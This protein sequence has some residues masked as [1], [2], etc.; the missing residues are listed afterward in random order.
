MIG[1]LAVQ[2]FVV[3]LF[4]IEPKKRSLEEIASDVSVSPSPAKP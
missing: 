4:G 2:I 1:L 3:L